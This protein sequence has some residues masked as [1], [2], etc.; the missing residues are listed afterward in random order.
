M[1]I[2]YSKEVIDTLIDKCIIENEEEYVNDVVS[3]LL[4]EIAETRCDEITLEMIAGGDVQTVDASSEAAADAVEK[5]E[6]TP[7]EGLKEER[8]SMTWKRHRQ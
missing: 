2:L 4:G 1:H 7:A 8:R 3:T 5:M 6:E